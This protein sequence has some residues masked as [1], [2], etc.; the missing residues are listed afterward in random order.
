MYYGNREDSLDSDRR[1]LLMV[2]QWPVY[3]LCVSGQ[4]IDKAPGREFDLFRALDNSN[5]HR[6]LPHRCAM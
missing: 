5:R 3:L 2:P 6:N 1:S 4:V